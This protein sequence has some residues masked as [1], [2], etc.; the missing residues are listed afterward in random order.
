MT[1]AGGRTTTAVPPVV[2]VPLVITVPPAVTVPPATTTPLLVTV[3]P[4]TPVT[5]LEVVTTPG[6]TRV[7]LPA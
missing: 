1:T 3:L 4:C 2:T 7:A 6:A 5:L